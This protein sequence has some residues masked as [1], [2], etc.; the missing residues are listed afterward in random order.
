MHF[1]GFSFIILMYKVYVVGT[2]HFGMKLYNDQRNAQV[3]NLFIYLLLPYMFRAFFKPIFRGRCINSAVVQV[4]W[5][6]CHRPGADS[7]SNAFYKCTATFRTQIWRYCLRIKLNGF[8]P[9]QTLLDITSN[10]FCK[11]TATF[12]THCIMCKAASII[13]RNWYQLVTF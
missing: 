5:V 2:V 1:V 9:V 8:G 6:W 4:S 12:R 3:F 7:T 11:C 13:R 10:A